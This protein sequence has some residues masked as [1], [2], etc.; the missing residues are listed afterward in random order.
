MTIEYVHGIL[1]HSQYYTT[2][3]YG[4]VSLNIHFEIVFPSQT[5]KI[6]IKVGP[7]S[8]QVMSVL[9]IDEVFL[10]DSVVVYDA[11]SLVEL[12]NNITSRVLILTH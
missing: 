2:W 12:Y 10:V 4:E 7:L 1:S 5:V 3:I 9:S 6:Q 8:L 11:N